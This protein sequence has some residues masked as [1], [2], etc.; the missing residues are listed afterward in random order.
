MSELREQL[1]PY[2]NKRVSVRGTFAAFD[3]TWKRGHRYTGRATITSPEI[4]AEVV[5]DHISVV[6]VPHWKDYSREATGRQVTFDAVVQS[7][8]DKN[9]KTNYCFGNAGELTIL[10]QPALVPYDLPR[11]PQP[12]AALTDDVP[13][14]APEDPQAAA[15]ETTME[16][17]RQA[18][19]FAK[20]CGGYDKAEEVVASLPSMPVPELLEYL[21]TLKE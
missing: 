6:D 14:E 4:D 13:E 3:T 19:A 20:A 8:T 7:Y 12:A 5:C 21:R 16:H 9:G 10:H 15:L 1:K 2:L 11:P 18:K 17:I